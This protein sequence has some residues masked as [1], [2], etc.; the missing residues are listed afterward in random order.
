M[1]NHHRLALKLAWTALLMAALLL[2]T[3]VREDFVYQAF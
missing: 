3:Q 2:L 1:K